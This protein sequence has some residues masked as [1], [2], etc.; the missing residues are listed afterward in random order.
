MQ[1]STILD[2]ELSEPLTKKP[3]FFK[4]QLFE[5][6]LIGL[7]CLLILVKPFLDFSKIEQVIVIY[8]YVI[9]PFLAVRIYLEYKNKLITGFGIVLKL[10]LLNASMTIMMGTLFKI[11]DWEGTNLMLTVSLMI[12]AVTHP[13]YALTLKS[14]TNEV[15]GLLFF[16]TLAAGLFAIGMI[17]K[18]GSWA[19]AQIIIMAGFVLILISL[20]SFGLF[21]QKELS[22]KEQYHAVNFVA[23]SVA[24]LLVGISFLF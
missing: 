19:N 2:Q 13:V 22:T 4:F 7:L 8:C 24:I 10:M 9:F 20:F 1:Q 11:L 18:M 5:F 17:F 23:R 15:K 21:Y 12:F 6:L 3:F 16:N 14:I